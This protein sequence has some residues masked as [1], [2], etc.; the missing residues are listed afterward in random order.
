MTLTISWPDDTTILNHWPDESVVK[1]FHG[2]D[3][4]KSSCMCENKSQHKGVLFQCYVCL[5]LCIRLP[6]FIS[7]TWDLNPSLTRSINPASNRLSSE[8]MLNFSWIIL[9][10]IF[11]IRT[12]RLCSKMKKY[13]FVFPNKSNFFNS[14]GETRISV[15]ETL[16]F[17]SR[18][19]SP[20]SL[21]SL[22]WFLLVL[23]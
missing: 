3:I 17:V 20:P 1:S 2:S 23:D 19:V 9:L 21:F 15:G 6:I 7:Q 5:Y 13:T 18:A 8:Q 11:V 22:F 12:Y 16:G 14:L 10:M 4:R